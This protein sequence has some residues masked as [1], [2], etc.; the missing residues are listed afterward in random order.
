[1]ITNQNKRYVE[2]YQQEADIDIH[3]L[4]HQNTYPRDTPINKVI[5][6]HKPFKSYDR[7][8]YSSIVNRIEEGEKS[9]SNLFYQHVT[10]VLSG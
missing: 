5:G 7:R 9:L 10:C 8:Q 4:G 6:N 1:M 3:G 2:A